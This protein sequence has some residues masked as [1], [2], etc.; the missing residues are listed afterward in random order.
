MCVNV[1]NA[2]DEIGACEPFEPT[3]EVP[4]PATLTLFGFGLA[5]LGL[6]RR[7]RVT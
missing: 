7:R 2:G 1:S 5:G 4:E 6:M 3:A